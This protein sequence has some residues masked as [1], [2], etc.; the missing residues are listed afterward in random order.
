[1]TTKLEDQ[2][3]TQKHKINPNV[4]KVSP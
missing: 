4:N 1:V 3:K 2:E